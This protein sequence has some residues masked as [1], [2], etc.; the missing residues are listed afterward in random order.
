[1]SVIIQRDCGTD[2]HYDDIP[3]GVW[4][5]ATVNKISDTRQIYVRLHGR[6]FMQ[7]ADA[8]IIHDGYSWFYKYEVV[9]RIA[10]EVFVQ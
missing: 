4:F 2:K 6:M 10:L 1:M 5:V 7:V 3:V 8:C 9:Q